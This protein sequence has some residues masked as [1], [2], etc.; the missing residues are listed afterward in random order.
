MCTSASQNAMTRTTHQ[1]MMAC[2]D[3]L[4]SSMMVRLAETSPSPRVAGMAAATQ[5]MATTKRMA[6]SKRMESTRR[7]GSSKRMEI[8]KR[9]VTETRM[10]AVIQRMETTARARMTTGTNLGGKTSAR[11]SI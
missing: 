1:V 3:Y 4:K 8:T 7:M 2:Y 5:R 10:V 6:I 11:V 9:A